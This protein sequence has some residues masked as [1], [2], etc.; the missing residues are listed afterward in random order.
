MKSSSFCQAQRPRKQQPTSTIQTI[1]QISW[2]ILMTA[3][4]PPPAKKL[5]GLPPVTE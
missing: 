1:S 3:P 5:S 4:P 2:G